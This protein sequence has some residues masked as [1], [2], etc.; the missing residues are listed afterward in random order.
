MEDGEGTIMHQPEEDKETMSTK[1]DQRT[2]QHPGDTKTGGQVMKGD[3][4]SVRSDLSHPEVSSWTESEPG[5][6]T[7]WQVNGGG[8]GPP[9]EAI[10]HLKKEAGPD[11]GNYLPEKAAQV[12]GPAAAV[13]PSSPKQAEAFW[14]M[15]SERSPFLGPQTPNLQG[16]QVHW[17]E[18]TPPARCK[19]TCCLT[20]PLPDRISDLSASPV[21]LRSLWMPRQ[22]CTE[23]GRVLD[24]ISV[25]FSILGVGGVCLPAV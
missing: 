19:C 18:D 9:G 20:C 12:F 21:C 23:G 7:G 13:L 5:L 25:P 2:L 15:E 3:R 24:D 14:D 8:A 22:R 10:E 4:G 16:S 11:G 1:M 17:M 6:K